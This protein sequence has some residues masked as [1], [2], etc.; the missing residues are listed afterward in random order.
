MTRESLLAA[1][2]RV[3]IRIADRVFEDEWNTI[4]ML[5]AGAREASESSLAAFNGVFD[6]ASAPDKPAVYLQP[7]MVQR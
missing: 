4:R 6:I 5:G 2:L 1:K 7:R 3:D